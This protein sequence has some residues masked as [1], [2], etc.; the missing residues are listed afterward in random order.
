MPKLLVKML[1]LV[2]LISLFA[3]CST[4][5]GKERK[6]KILLRWSGYSWQVYN[7]FRSEESKKFERENPNVIV[8]Y[9][10]IAGGN[11]KSKLLTQIASNTAPDMFFVPDLST[12]ISKNA[13][14]NLTQWYEEDKEYFKD[15]YPVLIDAHLWNGGLYALPGNCS[16]DILYYNKKLFDEKGLGYPDETWTWQD[17]L[18]AAQKLTIRDEKSGITQYGSIPSTGTSADWLSLILQNGGKI[19]NKDKTKCIINS[20]ESIEALEFWKDFYAKYKVAPTPS[21]RIDRGVR[22]LFLM[23]KAAMYWG[24]SWEVATFKIKARGGD[25]AWDATLI[26]RQEGKERFIG[27][28]YLSLGVWSGS[29]HPRLTYELAKFMTNPER[30][31]F[32][33]E[34]GDSLPIRPRGEAMDYYLK[35]PN[36]PEKAKE[37]M[38]KALSL[39]K[40]YYRTVVNPNIPYMEQD[41]IIGENLQ[42]F[43]IGDTS[44]GEVLQL[45][46]NRLNNILEKKGLGKISESGMRIRVVEQNKR[47]G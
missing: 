30:I 34:V 20:P 28:H 27:L 9:E 41:Q 3:G 1:G 2:I 46:Q 23:G 31:K 11:Y 35:D 38:L 6:N 17:F 5:R 8:K 22:E 39:S 24:S 26:P 15:I 18:E 21:V 43:T 13:L 4:E 7:K 29:K 12:Y 25:L 44:A 47:R 10:P 32:L 42:K 36:R 37:A 16:V 40:S 33:V 45:I 14:V 19:W